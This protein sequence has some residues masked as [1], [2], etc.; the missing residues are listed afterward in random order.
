MTCLSN[1]LCFQYTCQNKRGANL[2]LQFRRINNNAIVAES[3]DFDES[4]VLIVV[5]MATECY[6]EIFTFF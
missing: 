5:P 4:H 2:Y 3:Q 1:D 6:I